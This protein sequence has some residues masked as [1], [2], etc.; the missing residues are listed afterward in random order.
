MRELTTIKSMKWSTLVVDEGH[1]LKNKDSRL[2]R[3]LT[4][5]SSDFRI[6]LSGTPVQNR[7]QELLNLLT[8]LDPELVA[9]G[10]TVAGG[11]SVRQPSLCLLLHS[12]SSKECR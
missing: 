7:I 2:W 12:V 11:R 3:D 8:F 10:G 4:K 9:V 1:R 6:L 5:I